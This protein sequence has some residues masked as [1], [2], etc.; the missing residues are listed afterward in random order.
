MTS[1]R[2]PKGARLLLCVVIVQKGQRAAQPGQQAAGQ[3]LLRHPYQTAQR[4][5]DH[6]Q[7]GQQRLGFMG[8]QHQAQ[9]AHHQQGA[10]G[11]RGA[12]VQG[13]GRACAKIHAQRHK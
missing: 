3:W 5:R 11:A 1:R 9:G 2:A 8:V 7:Q 12:A 10:R 13:F 4:Q 6:R